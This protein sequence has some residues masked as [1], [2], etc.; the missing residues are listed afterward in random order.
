ML[1]M[2][3][4]VETRSVMV[5]VRVT[6][7]TKARIQPLIDAGTCVTPDCGREAKDRGV[8]RRCRDQQRR[9]IRTGATTEAELIRRGLLLKEAKRGRKPSG[10]LVNLLATN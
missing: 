1:V 3:Q 7:K 10:P 2:V 6:P 4:Q 9:A 8:C 5:E